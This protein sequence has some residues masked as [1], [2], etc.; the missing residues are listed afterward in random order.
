M[1]LLALALKQE[2]AGA[3][4]VSN[5]HLQMNG[6][7]SIHPMRCEYGFSTDTFVLVDN[8]QGL[9]DEYARDDP[10]TS[11][12]E[13]KSACLSSCYCTAYSY[14]SGC[15]IWQFKLHNLSLADNPP[16]SSIYV[17]LGSRE[18][19]GL[20][21]LQVVALVVCLLVAIVASGSLV[22]WLYKGLSSRKMKVEGFLIVYSYAQL[23]KATGNFSY[24]LG[25]G[26]FGSVFKGMI[27]GSTFVA[28]KNLKCSGVRIRRE[29]IPNRSTDHPDDSAN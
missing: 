1:A 2:N 26:G 6:I 29:T 23:K 28:V 4:T 13:C 14:S 21:K 9:P 27:A 10:A 17:R 5:R 15:K 7:L 18:K 25:E 16:Y 8:L 19:K 24:K 22:F 12:E 20:C 3:L 11:S